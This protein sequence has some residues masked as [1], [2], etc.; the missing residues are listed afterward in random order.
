MSDVV[1]AL[2]ETV[3]LLRGLAGER[4]GLTMLRLSS[5]DAPNENDPRFITV[6]ELDWKI[7][8]AWHE[9]KRL[10]QE[11]EKLSWLMNMKD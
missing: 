6:D 1:D 5:P 7:T 2:D 9:L 11:L 4:E 8:G 10:R 3:R